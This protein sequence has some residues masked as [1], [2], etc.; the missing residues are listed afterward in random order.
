MKLTS[1]QRAYLRSLASK[2]TAL[3]QIGK[4]N[5]TPEIVQAVE[6]AFNNREIVKL[7]VLKNAVEDPFAMGE[8]LAERSGSTLV[9][10][11]GRKI[12]LYKPF[13]DEPE[14]KLPK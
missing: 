4:S 6:E 8:A 7:S 10:I 13:K 2:E 1:K 11:I 14:I 5:L 9:E 12:V 3:F